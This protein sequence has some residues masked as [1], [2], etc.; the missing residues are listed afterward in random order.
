M[1]NP[2]EFNHETGT[3][4]GSPGSPSGVGGR[5]SFGLLFLFSFFFPPGANYMFM[6]LMKRGLVTMCGFFLI[7]F[8][9]ATSSWPFSMLFGLAIPI[10]VLTCIFDGF[11]VRRRMN[12]GEIIYDNIGDILG[13]IFR[14][15]TVLLVVLGILMLA[16]LGNL[17]GFAVAIIGRAI[18][19]IIIA[20]IVYVIVRRKKS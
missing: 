7:I 16:F 6:G 5:I 8:L 11:D 20:F 10:Y 13:G 18:P 9:T 19:I 14:N 17:L 4:P 3:P 1:Q 15:K 2:N 12:A